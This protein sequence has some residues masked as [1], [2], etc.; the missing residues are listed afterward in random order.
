M[1]I[2]KLFKIF[3]LVLTFGLAVPML[4]NAAIV[5]SP[6]SDSAADMR[7]LTVITNRVAEIQNMDKS[8]LTK[9][10]R[11]AL[12]KELREMKKTA[13]STNKNNNGIYLSIGAVI[14]IILLLILL[15]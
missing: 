14:I 2:K 3:T 13:E 15:L 12:K 9:A 1:N 8:Q 10:D 4:S 5:A 7:I 11:I 6:L